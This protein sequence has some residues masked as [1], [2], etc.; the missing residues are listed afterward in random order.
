[1]ADSD[2]TSDG[3]LN[4]DLNVDLSDREGTV[5]RL[6]YLIGE[7]SVPLTIGGVSLAALAGFGVV[8]LTVPTLVERF[9]LV[10][11]AY[12]VIGWPLVYMFAE[13]FDSGSEVRV[14][15]EDPLD[16]VDRPVEVPA[17][18]WKEREVVGQFDAWPCP[19]SSDPH[20]ADWKCRSLRY[21][22]D[23]EQLHVEGLSA[24]APKAEEIT[25]SHSY[26]RDIWETFQQ[27]A[28]KAQELRT[29]YHSY[30]H[31][32]QQHYVT[33]ATAIVQSGTQVDQG[34]GLAEVVDEV[35]VGERPDYPTLTDHVDPSSA[36]DD[37]EEIDV[38]NVENGHS[39]S[40]SDTDETDSDS[41]TQTDDDQE[42]EQGPI[43]EDDEP[44]FVQ[45]MNDGGDK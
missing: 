24:Y 12:S 40:D 28:R 44:R 36:D 4:V 38:E 3:P 16:D 8:N 43:P 34:E 39:D 11:A 31:R 29:Q 10:L 23:D 5:D 30:A 1:M 7:F 42:S 13:H 6:T 22:E 20:N 14:H 41:E 33:L 26:V 19:G 15:V 37:Q 27:E 18:T 21:D 45:N 9:I 2:G 35:D 32:L 17:R 25:Q